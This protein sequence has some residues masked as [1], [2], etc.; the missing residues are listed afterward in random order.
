MISFLR[1]LMFVALVLAINFPLGAMAGAGER[2]NAAKASPNAWEMP[3]IRLPDM[4][5]NE[6]QLYDWKGKVI[7]LNFWAAWCPPCLAEIPSL[8][9]LQN[10][11]QDKGFQIVSIGLD[12]PKK[13]AN[14]IR[15]LGINYPVLVADPETRTHLLKD[16]GDRQQTL[17]YTVIIG[18]DGAFHLTYPGMMND[19]IFADYV[20]PLL[21]DARGKT[22]KVVLGT[23]PQ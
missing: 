22:S 14:V 19:Q 7:L 4:A 17:P 18:A 15:S 13:L 20:L 10:R 5:G 9:E 23:M 6:R 12:K 21:E 3:P 8:V 2:Q 16:W 1:G 11:Y